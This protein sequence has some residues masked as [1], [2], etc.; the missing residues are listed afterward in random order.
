MQKSS[1]GRIL[2]QPCNRFAG[3]NQKPIADA[4]VDQSDTNNFAR[5]CGFNPREPVGENLHYAD[6]DRRV[7]AG[8][9]NFASAFRSFLFLQLSH[10]DYRLL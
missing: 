5:C 6:L 9:A 10:Q 8:Y 3:M 7:G 2:F 4:R 1:K